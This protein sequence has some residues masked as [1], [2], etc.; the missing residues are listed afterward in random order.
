MHGTPRMYRAC[1]DEDGPLAP[2]SWKRQFFT[3]E[4][5]QNFWQ[6][7]QQHGLYGFAI[8]IQIAKTMTFFDF[9][10]QQARLC[11]CGRSLRG[12]LIVPFWSDRRVLSIFSIKKVRKLKKECEHWKN[13]GNIIG[14][15]WSIS[16]SDLNF[17]FSWKSKKW[18]LTQVTPIT[19]V[20]PSGVARATNQQLH[21][22]LFAAEAQHWRCTEAQ[23]WIW[24]HTIKTSMKN[25]SP[26][27]VQ[28]WKRSLK[29]PRLEIQCTTGVCHQLSMS[30]VIHAEC[31][32]MCYYDLLC[33]SCRF[34]SRQR[35]FVFD[36]PAAEKLLS[37]APLIPSC[38]WPQSPVWPDLFCALHVKIRLHL[39]Q[40]F[41][42]SYVSQLPWLIVVCKFNEVRTFQQIQRMF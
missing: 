27:I 15:C 28:D 22:K 13:G 7:L 41:H 11:R 38:I 32:N 23:K 37:K 19:V 26:E 35:Q 1:I 34:A 40:D 42:V 18:V 17:W 30:P 12:D 9:N 20:S 25:R 29:N 36:F 8:I 4:Q 2:E 21:S 14:M 6:H 24:S 3:A 31:A 16:K 5:L 33:A 39:L 10:F